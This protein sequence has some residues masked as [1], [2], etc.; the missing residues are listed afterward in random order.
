MR[1][2]RFGATVGVVAWAAL[3][4]ACGGAGG[5]G[6]Y[7]TAE[8]VAAAY[9]KAYRAEPKGLPFEVED[10]IVGVRGK[11]AAVYV[12]LKG[13]AKYH[14][15]TADFQRDQLKKKWEGEG[16]FKLT[17][18]EFSQTFNDEMVTVR[19]S[20]AHEDAHNLGVKGG[21]TDT[22]FIGLKQCKVIK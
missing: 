10:Q 16:K 6:S 21:F 1:M 7:S 14:L 12:K 20:Y 19:W 8:A 18:S 9:E 15:L 13:E 17:K 3:I 11:E 4:A 5:G 2:L 22:N